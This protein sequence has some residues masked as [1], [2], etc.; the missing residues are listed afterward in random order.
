MYIMP[1]NMKTNRDR[2]V[3]I[4][5]TEGDSEF[6][7]RTVYLS[8]WDYHFTTLAAE[9]QYVDELARRHDLRQGEGHAIITE[10]ATGKFLNKMPFEPR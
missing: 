5:V 8:G 6:G 3:E 1:D 4:Y 9:R 7:W 10:T 2:L